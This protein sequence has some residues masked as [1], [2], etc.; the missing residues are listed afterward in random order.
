MESGTSDGQPMS[1]DFEEGNM[2]T[3]RFMEED[4]RGKLGV[5][6]IFVVVSKDAEDNVR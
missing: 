3:G 1:H 2:S 6:R 5:Y 4:Q